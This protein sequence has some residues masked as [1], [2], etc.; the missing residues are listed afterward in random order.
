MF[1]VQFDGGGNFVWQKISNGAGGD[2]IAL[3][4]EG[5]VYAASSIL[6]D[7]L[8]NFDLL[9]VKLT[10]GGAEV[11]RR[12]YS[13]G[14]IQRDVLAR[15]RAATPAARGRPPS[16]PLARDACAFVAL[17]RAPT[18]AATPTISTFFF[19]PSEKRATRTRA[20]GRL[21]GCAFR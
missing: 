5:S 13:A 7:E 3:G 18:R 4:P 20:S 11:W 6:R 21:A 10:A 17:R 8:A 9:V 2:A 19:T 15:R 12:T 16:R 1:V 14:V